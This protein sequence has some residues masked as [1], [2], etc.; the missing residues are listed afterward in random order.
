MIS[1]QSILPL[2]LHCLCFSPVQKTHRN[3][4]K[5]SKQLCHYHFLEFPPGSIKYLSIYYII[6][7]TARAAA[8]EAVLSSA[9]MIFAL[10]GV[11]FAF[12]V[13]AVVKR[14]CVVLLQVDVWCSQTQQ[15]IVGYYQANACVSDSR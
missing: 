12:D 4:C 10:A 14:R 13:N 11:D 7:Q 1:Q 15:R 2:N 3:I 9:E 6:F 5:S 8:E